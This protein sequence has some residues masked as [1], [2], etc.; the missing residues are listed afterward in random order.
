[1]TQSSFYEPV[2]QPVSMGMATKEISSTNDLISCYLDVIKAAFLVH[3]GKPKSGL[4]RAF[5]EIFCSSLLFPF[6]FLL[7]SI[8]ITHFIV[9]LPHGIS[10]GF[11]S[12][13]GINLI[14]LM[15]GQCFSFF[16]PLP[17]QDWSKPAK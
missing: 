9:F 7:M 5:F 6:A 11:L 2:F 13:K 12:K 8:F 15:L 1:M 3:A 16:C 4:L 14:N 10:T 17:S